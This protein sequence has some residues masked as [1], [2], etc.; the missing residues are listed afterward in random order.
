MIIRIGLLALALVFGLVGCAE[1]RAPSGAQ[2]SKD[3]FGAPCR[4]AGCAA[5]LECRFDRPD[6]TW[7]HCAL[8]PG[9]CRFVTDCPPTFSCE[10][11]ESSAAWI[12]ACVPR[13]E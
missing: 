2:T 10:K 3:G 5:G 1:R 7:G 8:E 11:P 13:V 4:A 9:R 12:G 6:L